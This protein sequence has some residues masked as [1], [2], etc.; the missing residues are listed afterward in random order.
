MEDAVC[1]VNIQDR[2]DVDAIVAEKVKSLK[3]GFD[4][5]VVKIKD[6]V[7]DVIS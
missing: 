5:K 6:R 2:V 1:Q 7:Q 4:D 3:I